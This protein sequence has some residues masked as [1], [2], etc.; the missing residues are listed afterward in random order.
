MTEEEQTKMLTIVRQYAKLAL[1]DPK[2]YS[3]CYDAA[4]LIA[5]EVLEISC[6]EKTANRIL[7]DTLNQAKASRKKKREEEH[8]MVL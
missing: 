7:Q 1:A 6:G 5:F 2:S 3:D 4:S 8:G